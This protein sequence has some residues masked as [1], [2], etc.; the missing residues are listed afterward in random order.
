MKKVDF[1][2]PYS[3]L[4]PDEYQFRLGPVLSIGVEIGKF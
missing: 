2:T 3:I 1:N 4:D